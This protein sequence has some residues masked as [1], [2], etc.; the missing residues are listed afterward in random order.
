M[1]ELHK[2]VKVEVAGDTDEDRIVEAKEGRGRL[3][4]VLEDGHLGD[5][6]DSALGVLTG[7]ASL[8][9]E[10][11]ERPTDTSRGGRDG[12]CVGLK[13]ELVLGLGLV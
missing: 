11:R 13:L 10:E 2:L 4:R 8:A 6:W 7:E 1:R 5:G 9:T 3:A 12:G